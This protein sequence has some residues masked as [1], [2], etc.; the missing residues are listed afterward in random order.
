MLDASMSL[1]RHEAHAGREA[2]LRPHPGEVYGRPRTT[3]GAGLQPC[4][5]VAF[6]PERPLNYSGLK[7]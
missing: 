4:G 1:S 7:R 6:V 3:P 2:A 5:T